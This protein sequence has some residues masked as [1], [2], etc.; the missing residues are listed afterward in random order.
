MCF[1]WNELPF[2]DLLMGSRD[3]KKKPVVTRSPGINSDQS[4]WAEQQIREAL[5]SLIMALGAVHGTAVALKWESQIMT[6]LNYVKGMV[7]ENPQVAISTVMSWFCEHA[8]QIWEDELRNFGE[9]TKSERRARLKEFESASPE[10]A[11]YWSCMLAKDFPVPHPLSTV[12]WAGKKWQE[13]KPRLVDKLLRCAKFTTPNQRPKASSEGP[14]RPGATGRHWSK[15]PS[16]AD[17]KP[18]EK[19][20]HLAGLRGFTGPQ[21]HKSSVNDWD[22]KPGTIYSKTNIHYRLCYYKHAFK[23]NRCKFRT[24]VRCNALKDWEKGI[25]IPQSG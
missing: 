5:D 21:C 15:A 11:E 23:K 25:P 17:A 20:T 10:A 7:S 9:E 19:T 13:A 4:S 24:C 3:A 18:G 1:S 16:I 14:P 6:E 22:S 2:L 8:S 12:N